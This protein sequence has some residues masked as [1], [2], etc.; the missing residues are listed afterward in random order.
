MGSRTVRRALLDLGPPLSLYF[1][2]IH[3]PVLR[4]MSLAEISSYVDYADKIARERKRNR[5]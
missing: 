2:G 3:P 1:P 5:G 4:Q